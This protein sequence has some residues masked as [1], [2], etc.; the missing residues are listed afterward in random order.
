MVSGRTPWCCDARET[1]DPPGGPGPSFR[2]SWPLLGRLERRIGITGQAAGLTEKGGAREAN[3]DRHAIGTGVFAVADGVGGHVGGA[4]AAERVVEHAVR[5]A[6]RMQRALARSRRSP[7]RELL[8][9]IPA[10]CQALLR[11]EAAQHPE[12]AGMATTW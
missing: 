9:E 2:R 4:H 6:Q 10:R 5:L 11:D 7:R 3:Q 8:A 1:A 12:L